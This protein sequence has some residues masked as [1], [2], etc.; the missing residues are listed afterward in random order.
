MEF[1]YIF[2]ARIVGRFF[3]HGHL[4]RNL[5]LEIRL[6]IGHLNWQAAW[7]M[8]HGLHQKMNLSTTQIAQVLPKRLLKT[9][10]NLKMMARSMKA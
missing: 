5:S 1:L 4:C 8:L 3:P 7:M 6:C 2:A 9:S 10:R